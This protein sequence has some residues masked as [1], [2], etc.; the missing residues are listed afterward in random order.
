MEIKTG[1]LNSG[2]NAGAVKLKTEQI[3]RSLRHN[4]KMST[5][6]KTDAFAYI[7]YYE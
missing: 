6:S 3:L 2:R 1:S 4:K 5:E 7:N